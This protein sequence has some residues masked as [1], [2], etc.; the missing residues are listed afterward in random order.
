MV[1]PFEYKGDDLINISSGCVAPKD[2]R[3]HLVKSCNIEQNGDNSFFE[4]RM[5]SET[6]KI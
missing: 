3:D 5:T 6:E 2:T 4:D 1:N